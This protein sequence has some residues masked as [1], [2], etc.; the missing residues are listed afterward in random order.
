MAETTLIMI[1]HFP[2]YRSQVV[3]LAWGLW[4]RDAKG[5]FAARTARYPSSWEYVTGP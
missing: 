4:E 3:V 2:P 1:P 5:P